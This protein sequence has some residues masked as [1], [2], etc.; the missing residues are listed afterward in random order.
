M[1]K[2]YQVTS[3]QRLV[4]GLMKVLLGLGLAPKGS[5]ILT[6][7]GRKSGK[8]YSLPVT[9]V[10]EDGQRWLVSPYGEVNWVRNARAAGQV[11]LRRGSRSE[12]VS[13]TELG[14]EE[15]APVL[16]KYLTAIPF[17]QPYFDAQPGSP[18]PAFVAEAPRH[19]VFLLK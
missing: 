18:L 16:Q 2:A 1:A 5:Y 8:L 15:S 14:P 19:P 3:V 11:T 10:E 13:F 6:V 4:N 17:V 7:P 12:T 9:L